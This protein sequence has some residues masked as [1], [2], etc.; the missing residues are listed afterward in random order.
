MCF[1]KSFTFYVFW[2]NIKCSTHIDVNSH[3]L[4][5]DNLALELPSCIAFY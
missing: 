2:G 1:G 4:A 5:C 3:V